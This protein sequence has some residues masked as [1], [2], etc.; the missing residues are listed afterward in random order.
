MLRI[1]CKNCGVEIEG[2]GI[3]GCPNMTR[4]KDD[5]ILGKDLSLIEVIS[6]EFYRNKQRQN[7]N[8]ILSPEDVEWHLTRQNRKVKKLE[9][10][11]R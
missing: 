2:N 10:E 3:C 7:K 5:K 11:I 9:F 6:G 8:T 1:R 4:L